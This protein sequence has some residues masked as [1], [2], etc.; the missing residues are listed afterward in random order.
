L[1]QLEYF[2]DPYEY[3]K[4]VFDPAIIVTSI[5]MISEKLIGVTYKR[6]ND[7]VEVMNNTNPI[8]AAYTTAH[9]R[10]KLYEYLEQLGDRV[11]YFDTDSVIYLSN[12]NTNQYEVPVGWH[13]G[14]MTNELKDYGMHSYISE[15]VSGGPKN[16]AYK[17]AGTDNG[18][19]QCEIKVRGITLSKV[20]SKRVNFKSL[21][22]LVKHL[23]KKNKKEEVVIVTNRIERAK[24]GKIIT[25][26]TSK[27]FRVVYDKRI[28]RKNYTTVPY[29]W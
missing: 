29:G 27:T 3:F 5:V 21:R 24:R 20:T 9:A 15:F 19:D 28:L 17:I 10:L 18:K 12:L 2:A 7:F 4:L 1:D 14:E 11:L 13:L 26:T 16:Y 6:K 22:R 23:V 8:I 25:K